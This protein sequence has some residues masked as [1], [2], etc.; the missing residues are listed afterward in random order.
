VALKVLLANNLTVG[1]SPFQAKSLLPYDLAWQN[2]IKL[3]IDW[4]WVREKNK[5][6]HPKQWWILAL[7]SQKKKFLYE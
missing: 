3:E 7:I 2:K 4:Y 5:C 6:I 1:V